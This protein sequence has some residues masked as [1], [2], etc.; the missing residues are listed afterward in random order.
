MLFYYNINNRSLCVN[1]N[2]ND[3]EIRF[4]AYVNANE[5]MQSSAMVCQWHY[6]KTRLLRYVCS[7]GDVSESSLYQNDNFALFQLRLPLNFFQFLV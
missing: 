5:E 3:L 7:K 1:I 4:E 6:K 2:L